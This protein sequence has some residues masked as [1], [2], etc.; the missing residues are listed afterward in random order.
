MRVVA[1]HLWRS[2]IFA[3]VFFLRYKIQVSLTVRAYVN[4]ASEY[5]FLLS[6]IRLA[7]KS[8]AAKARES[9]K[10]DTC[11]AVCSEKPSEGNNEIGN[12]IGRLRKG[13]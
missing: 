4:R 9:N 6:R 7:G 13:P 2:F 1:F 8:H 10:I 11:Y 3:I 5:T 12:R